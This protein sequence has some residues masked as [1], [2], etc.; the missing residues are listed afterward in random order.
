MMYS[1]DIVNFQASTT[2]L[3]ACTKNSGN[4]L[5]VT[6]YSHPQTDLFRSI[7]THQ[8][9]STLASHNWDRNPVDS[10]VKPNFKT[11]QPREAISCDVNFKRLWITIIIVYIHPFN[12]YRDLN[13]YMKRLAIYANGDTITSS[14]ENLTLR[15]GGRGVIY[16]Y[17]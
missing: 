1:N 17:I 12:G 6:I 13:S 5:N 8:C 11:I 10:N 16:I 7:R 9:G 2:N 14:P 4:L 3:N 15:Y